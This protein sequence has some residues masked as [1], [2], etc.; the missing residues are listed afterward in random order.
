MI[1]EDCS[2]IGY[3]SKPHGVEGNLILRL[4][5]SFAD[6][7]EPGES[8][9]VEIDGALVPFFIEEITPIGEKAIIKM[10]FIDSKPVAERYISCKAFYKIK[11]D[12]FHKE[13][14]NLY[15]SWRFTDEVSG[16]S[17]EIKDY[18]D[19]EMNPSFLVEVEGKEALIPVSEDFV[20]QIDSG[21]KVL[22]LKLP[23]GLLEL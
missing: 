13:K 2:Q 9:F 23:E 14:A 4:N 6:E 22:I 8:L 1:G 16:K 20:S 17:G 18:S 19:N 10:E 7:I 15:L 21:K 12:R 11:T 3:L 5:G